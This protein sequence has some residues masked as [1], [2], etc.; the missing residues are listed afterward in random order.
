LLPAQRSIPLFSR[1]LLEISR[2][3]VHH[4]GC[5]EGI[6]FLSLGAD[7]CRDEPY[8]A[9]GTERQRASNDSLCAD[10]EHGEAEPLTRGLRRGATEKRV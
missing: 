6:D 1:I 4:R 10:V 2:V 8:Q 5:G 9:G 7:V 3:G